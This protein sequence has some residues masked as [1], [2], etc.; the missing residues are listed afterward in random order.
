MTK[1][2]IDCCATQ[3]PAT[4]PAKTSATARTRTVVPRADIWQTEDG[5]HL[6]IELPG[7]SKENL[8]LRIE[9]DRLIVS[10]TPES[11]VPDGRARHLEWRPS[12]FERAFVLTDDA[13]RDAIDAQL[14][15]GLLTVTIPRR[16][17]KRPRSIDV[18]VDAD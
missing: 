11:A 15:N 7:V 2:A 17:E 6:A 18:R 4:T 14:K 8:D 13:D 9:N 1:N 16:A 3:T 12:A 10:A 5:A